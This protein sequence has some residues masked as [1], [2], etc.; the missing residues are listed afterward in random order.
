M[1]TL[2]GFRESDQAEAG[3][4]SGRNGKKRKSSRQVA[5]R[6]RRDDVECDDE[7]KDDGAKW[8]YDDYVSDQDKKPAATE[9]KAAKNKVKIRRMPRKSHLAK[10]EN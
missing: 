4:A 5:S 3:I 7:V 2:R 6:P 8:K 1:R 10:H 9:R